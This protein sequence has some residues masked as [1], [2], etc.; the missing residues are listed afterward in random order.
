MTLYDKDGKEY[1]VPHKVDQ[2][3]WLAT[4]DYFKENPKAKKETTKK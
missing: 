2:R 1:K 3:E 4:G